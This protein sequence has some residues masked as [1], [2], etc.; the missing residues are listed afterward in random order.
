MVKICYSSSLWNRTHNTKLW[1]SIF[2][3]QCICSRGS[4]QTNNL[5]FYSIATTNKSLIT[6]TYCNQE[7]HTYI[8]AYMYIIYIY[9][10]SMHNISFVIWIIILKYLL[11]YQCQINFLYLWL[12][13]YFSRFCELSLGICSMLASCLLKRSEKRA[14][15]DTSLPS[16][17]WTALEKEAGFHRDE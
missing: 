4:L 10:C 2:Y 16:S 17:S 14:L 11:L 13:S 1:W 3:T 7:L 6:V 15:D 8:H 12:L 9:I 5:C